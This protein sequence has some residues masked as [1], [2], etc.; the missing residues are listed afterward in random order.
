MSTFALNPVRETL[1]SRISELEEIEEEREEQYKGDGSTPATWEKV[2]PSI[3]RG[4]VEE[5]LADL[6]EVDDIDDVLRTIAEWRWKM[7]ENWA[8][9]VTESK[10]VNER[11]RIKQ[12]EMR[13][14]I[15]MLVNSLSDDEFN[16]CPNCGSK[17]MPKR[18][19][20]YSQGYDWECPDCFV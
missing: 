6:E 3:R 15:D 12:S 4:V 13:S 9:K 19:R 2:E 8:F 20:R 5:C 14:K 1:K 10:I 11:H 7:D 16:S 18:D 17:K